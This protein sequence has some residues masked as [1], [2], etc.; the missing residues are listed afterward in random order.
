MSQFKKFLRPLH[1]SLHH[2]VLIKDVEVFFRSIVLYIPTGIKNKQSME[3]NAF[4]KPV[5]YERLFS[6]DE[7]LESKH[8]LSRENP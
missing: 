3:R 1:V 2:K 5:D 7:K 4:S 6:I 8:I